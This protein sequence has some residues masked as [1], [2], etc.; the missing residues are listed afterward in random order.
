LAGCLFAAA[1]EQP[2]I[3]TMMIGWPLAFRSFEKSPTRHSGRGPSVRTEFFSKVL[4]VPMFGLFIFA[5][6]P[7]PHGGVDAVARDVSGG[8]RHQGDLVA[9]R[10][11]TDE[12]AGPVTWGVWM[13]M[14]ERS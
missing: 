9:G 11:M 5:A 13:H 3:A 4:D 7:A 10:P 14:K 8:R 6:A 2:F 12:E 1:S